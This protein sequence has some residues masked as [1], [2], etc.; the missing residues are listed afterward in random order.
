MTQDELLK[1]ID[2]LRLAV[3]N[4]DIEAICTAINDFRIDT[5]YSTPLIDF[6]RDIVTKA[7]KE[8]VENHGG[9]LRVKRKGEYNNDTTDTY[10]ITDGVLMRNR[11][12]VKYTSLGKLLSAYRK[13]KKS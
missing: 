4:S 6:T 3:E 8:H 13:I 2:S 5:R 12:N 7:I 1:R 9:T 11:D 10:T